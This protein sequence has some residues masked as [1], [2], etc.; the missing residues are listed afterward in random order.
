[1]HSQRSSEDDG[2]LEPGE[3]YELENLTNGKRKFYKDKE[4]DDDP[5]SVVRKVVPETDDPNQ[6]TITSRCLFLGTCLCILGG[7]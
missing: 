4:A 6:T 2:L 5:I 7:M 1:M 3:D